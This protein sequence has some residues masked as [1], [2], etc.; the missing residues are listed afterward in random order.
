L[1][2]AAALLSDGFVYLGGRFIDTRGAA[3]GN[4]CL[5]GN[6]QCLQRAG[7][8]LKSRLRCLGS[9]LV[10]M[11]CGAQRL[12]RG[13]ECLGGGSQILGGRAVYTGL[14]LSKLSGIARELAGTG[15]ILGNS[16]THSLGSLVGTG[17]IPIDLGLSSESLSGTFIGGASTLQ[18]LQSSLQNLASRLLYASACGSVL[19]TCLNRIGA[20]TGIKSVAIRFVSYYPKRAYPTVINW[21]RCVQ[22]CR[23]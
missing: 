9:Y 6:T 15:Q 2:R 4:P 23:G 7:T 13:L 14:D 1:C 21:A 16:F 22:V 10:H 8:G 20:I 18:T 19:R 12:R 17:C 3:R 11:L 5:G